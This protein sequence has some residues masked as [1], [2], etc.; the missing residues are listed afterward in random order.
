VNAYSLRTRV[1]RVRPGAYA[2]VIY[3]GAHEP[4]VLIADTSGPG[5]LLRVDREGSSDESEDSGANAT[6]WIVAGVGVLAIAAVAVFRR[7]RA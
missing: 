2:F 6:W 3:L 7:R 5:R 1:P 4:G